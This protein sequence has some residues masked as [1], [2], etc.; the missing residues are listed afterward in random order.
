MEKR[1]VILLA[2][3]ITAC[4]SSEYSSGDGAEEKLLSSFLLPSVQAA[5]DNIQAN[6]YESALEILNSVLESKNR[7]SLYDR[8][9]LLELRAVAK[10]RLGH[11]EGAR[12][13]AE[14]AYA[15][16]A[17]SPARQKLLKDFIDSTFQ[18]TPDSVLSPIVRMPPQI[19]EE[20]AEPSKKKENEADS[21]LVTVEL[22]FDVSS[23]G[24]PENILVSAS[25][26]ECFNKASIE[27]VRRWRYAP[28]M[29]N[30]NPVLVKAQKVA[31]TYAY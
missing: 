1:I 3:L 8:A 27:A 18:R 6:E 17:F 28:P 4:V 24:I 20:C 14:A 7:L 9:T 13:D 25:T 10:K 2:C 15:L 29:Q 12:S 30:G 16:N 31:I 21:V 22:V 11:W 19:P 26:N 5:Y 23:E